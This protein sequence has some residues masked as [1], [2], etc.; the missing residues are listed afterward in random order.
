MGSDRIILVQLD[1]IIDADRSELAVATTGTGN[2]TL[3]DSLTTQHNAGL[4]QDIATS[5]IIG[6]Q[7]MHDLSI[8]PGVVESLLLGEFDGFGNLAN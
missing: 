6:L 4:Q 5:L 8:R 7:R 1:A 3:L 2:T